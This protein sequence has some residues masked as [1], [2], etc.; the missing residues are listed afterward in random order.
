MSK[1]KMNEG[2]DV[3]FA[4][5]YAIVTRNLA[6]IPKNKRLSQIKAGCEFL[7][8]LPKEERLQKLKKP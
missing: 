7:L 2:F 5:K 1:N 4:I 6:V 3:D 8:I